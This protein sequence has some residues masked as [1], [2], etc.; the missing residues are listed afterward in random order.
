MKKL[1]DDPALMDRLSESGAVV[2]HADHNGTLYFA[3][4][5]FVSAEPVVVTRLVLRDGW[6]SREEVH[7]VVES[8][9]Q[10]K[11]QLSIGE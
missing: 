1:K 7:L 3:R 11:S 5:R 10:I 9:E 2:T 8:P 4:T 6:R